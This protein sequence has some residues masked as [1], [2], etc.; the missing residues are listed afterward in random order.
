MNK[1]IENNYKYKNQLDYYNVNI[2]L[3]LLVL[4]NSYF[5]PIILLEEKI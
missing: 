3:L 4:C 2:I 5:N 1:Y